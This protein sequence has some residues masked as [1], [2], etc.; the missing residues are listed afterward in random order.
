VP[1]TAF[2]QKAFPAEKA[3][4]LPCSACG[5]QISTEAEACPQCGHPNRASPRAAAEPR[6][7]A[8]SAPATTRC[9]SCGA[10]S[11]AQHLQNIFVAYGQG[12]GGAYELRCESC[13]SSAAAWRTFNWILFGIVLII[14]AI[15]FFG[16]WLPG[17]F[18]MQQKHKEFD[19]RWHQER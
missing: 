1:S 16:V 7:Y 5:R 4:L 18:D 14:I 2:Q 8:C 19:Q 3:Q 13:Y 12:G 9:Q 10:F 11:C 17:W 15:F 6:C